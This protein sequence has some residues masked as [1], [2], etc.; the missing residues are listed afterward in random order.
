[1]ITEL[2]AQSIQWVMDEEK[3]YD[4]PIGI[5]SWK[6]IATGKYYAEMEEHYTD[7]EVDT[8]LVKAIDNLPV[9]AAELS[10]DV[11]FGAWCGDSKEQLPHFLK[12]MEQSLLLQKTEVVYIGCDREK[13]AG[14]LDISEVNIEFVPT[15]IFLLDG[16]E[17]GRIVE[18]PQGTSEQSILNILKS[19]K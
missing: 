19:I 9:D 12:I 2:N 11:Y 17:I 7:Y 15:F 4:V 13:K 3:G 1:M 8:K 16:K 10:I 14:E 18:V 6:D 5:C